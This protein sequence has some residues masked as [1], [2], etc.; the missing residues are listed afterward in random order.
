[1]VLGEA[2]E[3]ADGRSH[4]MAGLLPVATSFRRRALHLGYRRAT[5]CVAT[6]FA[7]RGST[8][9]GHE[10][11]YAALVRAEGEPIATLEVGEGVALAPAGTRAGV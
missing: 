6:P 3:D 9:I 5:C 8:N 7:P 11:H 10:Y 4:A 1:M 2:I